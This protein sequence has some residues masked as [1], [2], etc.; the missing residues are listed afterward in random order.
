[1]ENS[2]Y[3]SRYRQERPFL[4]T[5]LEVWCSDLS[6]MAAIVDRGALVSGRVKT[7]R[8]VI[9]KVFRNPSATRTW[10]SLGDLIAMKAIFPTSMGVEAFTQEIGLRTDWNPS[11]DDRV[12]RPDRLEYGSKQ[13]D[14]FRAD[15][16]DSG[17]NAIKV[18]LQVRTAAADAWYV[19]DHRLNYKGTVRLPDALKRKVLRLTVLAE[20]FDQEVNAIIDAQ[21]SLEEYAVA[22]AY[23]GL[24]DVIDGITDGLAVT[25]RP[26]ALMETLLCAYRESEVKE[27]EGIVSRFVEG[28]EAV[29]RDVVGKH[30]FDSDAFVERRDWIYSEPEAVLIAERALNGPSMLREALKG[31]NYQSLISPMINAFQESDAKMCGVVEG[32]P[33][34]QQEGLGE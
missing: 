15:V 13:F 32:D 22:R 12:P 16:V 19:V 14:L 23:D 17:G 10:E 5:G 9:G 4:E 31:S 25:S 24:I 6:A 30:Q 8:S 26:E 3:T 7:H 20:M 18:E 28:K 33:D 27:L 21:S 34:E 1:M 2:S 29:L 11:L